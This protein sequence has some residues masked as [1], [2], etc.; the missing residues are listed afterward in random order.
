MTQI[1]QIKAEIV[2]LKSQLVRG[3]CAAGIAMETNCKEEA[4]NE[5]LAFIDSL[6][7]VSES[8]ELEAEF[9][10]W[11]E[12]VSG[13]INIE[14]SMFWYMEQC[15]RH[16]AA[17]QKQQDESRKKAN[18]KLANTDVP[19]DEEMEVAFNDIWDDAEITIEKNGG[20][21]AGLTA[22]FK[23]LCHDFFESGKTWQKKQ[24]DELLT[25]AH[26]DGVQ[27]GKEAER[28]EMM[29][30]AVEGKLDCDDAGSW[31]ELKKDAVSP[32]EAGD[33]VKLIILKVDEN[34]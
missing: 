4:Y 8:P 7:A 1:E 3:A 14:H 34:S 16:F 28:K 29:K 33:K 18:I 31:V 23:A 30:Q 6:L 24:D 9:K 22:T 12:S 20:L 15:A 5:V 32:S 27:S 13:K 2:R 21:D 19:V 10:K 25:I 17:W 26:F 11:W